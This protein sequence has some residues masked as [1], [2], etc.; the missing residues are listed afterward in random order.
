MSKYV[1]GR[2]PRGYFDDE[3]PDQIVVEMVYVPEH[4]AVDTGLVDV[5]GDPILRL[6]NPVG[7]GRDKEW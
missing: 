2:R 5:T 4:V 3:Y 7:F 1:T 6:P